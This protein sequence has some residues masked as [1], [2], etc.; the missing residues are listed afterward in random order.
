MRSPLAAGALIVVLVMVAACQGR[1]MAEPPQVPTG[2]PPYRIGAMTITTA[3]VSLAGTVTI[4]EGPG[5]F[6]TVIIARGAGSAD[7]DAA[8][9][10]GLTRRGIVVLRADGRGVGLS[11]GDAATATPDALADDIVA[12]VTRV[13]EIP[14]VDP[15]RIG[16]V[17]QGPGAS[18]A[19][20]SATRS[21]SIAFVAVL[22][23]P[24]AA[25]TVIAKVTV[26]VYAATGDPARADVLGPLATWITSRR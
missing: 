14:S 22:S 21:P 7:L 12:M 25:Q 23:A 4:P 20:L 17:G 13:K 8:L 5:P 19:A 9:A 24:R 6:P 15:A 10:D 1:A 3:T 2:R 18:L 16:V 26:P 11:T